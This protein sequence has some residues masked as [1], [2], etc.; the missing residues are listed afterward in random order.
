[1]AGQGFSSGQAFVE[2]V[3]VIFAGTEKVIWERVF[4]EWMERLRDFEPV[5]ATAIAS[6][7]IPFINHI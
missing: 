6:Q 1:L 3:S 5:R 2:A 4:L 7:S